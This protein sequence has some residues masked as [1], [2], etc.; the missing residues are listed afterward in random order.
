MWHTR[1]TA[2]ERGF[3]LIELL[4]VVLIVGVLAAIAVPTY[5]NQRKKAAAASLKAD[6]AAMAKAQETWLID[7]PSRPGYMIQILPGQTG[8]V[9]GAGSG[10]PKVT[11]SPGNTITVYAAYPGSGELYDGS[12]C[13]VGENPNSSARSVRASDGAV[14]NG[15]YYYNAAAGGGYTTWC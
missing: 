15:N 8:T 7:N 12:Y 13:I 11:T 6:M 10:G 14:I 3:T 5:L 2:R 9:G 4:V 1:T